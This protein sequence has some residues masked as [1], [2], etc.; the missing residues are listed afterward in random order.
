MH[1]I[2]GSLELHVSL[3]KNSQSLLSTSLCDKKW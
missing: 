2:S 1:V 3:K